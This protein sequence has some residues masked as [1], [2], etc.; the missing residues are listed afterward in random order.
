MKA[1]RQPAC[2]ERIEGTL[3]PGEEPTAVIRDPE[4]GDEQVPRARM[5]SGREVTSRIELGD[6]RHLSPT[7]Q[8][9][10]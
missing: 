1:L 5:N 2:L 10:S 8:S 4:P 7:G 6:H 9:Q 3:E